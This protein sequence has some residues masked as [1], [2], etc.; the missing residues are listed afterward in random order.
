M[1]DRASRIEGESFTGLIPGNARR[2]TIA[3]AASGDR[4]VA[5]PYKMSV[6]D[7]VIIATTALADA[8][9]IIY[10]PSVAEAA[11]RI[12]CVVAPTGS[13]GGDISVYTREGTP[14]EISTYG[15]LD[16][17]GD[18]IVVYSTGT[19]WAVIGSLLG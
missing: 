14:A 6:S 13:T 3:A 9:A 1:S 16:A 4:T 11:G 8:A 7:S 5:T 17:D 12:Y 2:L 19:A 18:Y 10:L 15:D